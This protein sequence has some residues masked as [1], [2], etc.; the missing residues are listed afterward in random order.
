MFPIQS[1]AARRATD[2]ARSLLFMAG[3]SISDDEVRDVVAFMESLTDEQFLKD[4][5]FGNPWRVA[6]P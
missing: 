6:K 4:P 1:S 3:F 2:F 5:R